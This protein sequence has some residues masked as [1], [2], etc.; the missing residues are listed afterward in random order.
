MRVQSVQVSVNVDMKER[1]F[2]ILMAIA[3]RK[4]EGGRKGG[5]REREREKEEEE[6]GE[7]RGLDLLHVGIENRT[8]AH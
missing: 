6:E 3:K 7:G 1:L 4:K 5:E 2:W 8:V